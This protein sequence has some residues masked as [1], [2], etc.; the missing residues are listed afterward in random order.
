MKKLSRF[1][2][3]CHKRNIGV[4]LHGFTDDD[5]YFD[6]YFPRE[7]GKVTRRNF[8]KRLQE[9]NQEKCHII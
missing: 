2:N 1:A 7:L 6:V 4:L 5:L 9:D 3:Y 8:E